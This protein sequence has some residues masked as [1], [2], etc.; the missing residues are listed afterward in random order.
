MT[1]THPNERDVELYLSVSI[2]FFKQIK[3][4]SSVFETWVKYLVQLKC[5]TYLH[6]VT[7]LVTI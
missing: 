4:S 2:G 7:E 3:T 5:V 1:L 6:N